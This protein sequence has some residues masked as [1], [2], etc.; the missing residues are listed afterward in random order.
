[1]G[2]AV[3][4]FDSILLLSI[5]ILPFSMAIANAPLNI[6]S[7]VIVA[8]YLLKKVALKQSMRLDS[9]VAI[10]L[11][12]FFLI[13]CIS[14]AN[15]V[16]IKD[17]LKGGI[18]RLLWYISILFILGE[19]ISNAKLL[20]KI[21]I[22]VVFSLCLVSINGIW[23][24]AVGKDFIRGYE[25]IINIGLVR[26]TASFPDANVLGTFLSALAPLLFGLTLYYYEGR[27]KAL[28]VFLS[29]L[30][31]VGIVITYSRP[32]LLATFIVFLFF[33]IIKKDKK[34]LFI[35]IIILCAA[36]LL[37]PRSVK[38]WV[39]SNNYNPL[40]VMCND[41]RIAIYRN[42][43]NMIKAHPFLGVGANT[44]MKNYRHY[45]EKPEYLNQVTS[46]YCYAH[47]NFFQMAAEIG[48]FGLTVFIWF[49]YNLFKSLFKIHACLKDNYLK[50]ICLSLIASLLSF[51]INGLTES[52]FYSSRIAVIFWYFAGMCLGLKS[53]IPKDAIRS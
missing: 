39:R 18:G 24:V 49:L 16:D 31:I 12:I 29:F 27:K 40:R 46:D 44:F 22:S 13:T 3:R 17:T 10:P 32:T 43:F 6:F 9:K 7:G 53:F 52:S 50:I 21:F 34:L 45:K 37:A 4:L 48:L 5:V 19:S 35:L 26:A 14:I 42:S 15:S 11:V 47:N 38:D 1:M 33:G 30:V 23:Q 36:P 8:A 51:L 2:R 20:N 41:D 25:P 28:L